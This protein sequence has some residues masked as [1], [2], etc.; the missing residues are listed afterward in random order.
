M[1]LEDV[2]ICFGCG[3]PIHKP[4]AKLDVDMF[5]CYDCFWAKYPR[6]PDKRTYAD[7]VK[8]IEAQQTPENMKRLLSRWIG[9]NK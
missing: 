3:L 9:K 4:C 8:E 5:L 7:F 6:K 1:S 2:A